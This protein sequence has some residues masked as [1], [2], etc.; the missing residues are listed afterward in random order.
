MDKVN[1]NVLRGTVTNP[2]LLDEIRRASTKGDSTP[3][4]KP[5]EINPAGAKAIKSSSLFDLD[6]DSLLQRDV[7]A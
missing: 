7:T 5:L 1:L 2:A 4:I 6:L 3:K